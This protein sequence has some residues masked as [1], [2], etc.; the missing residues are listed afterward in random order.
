MDKDSLK[1]FT[2]EKEKKGKIHQNNA[3]KKLQNI[4]DIGQRILSQF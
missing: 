1:M 4:F 3:S 2:N